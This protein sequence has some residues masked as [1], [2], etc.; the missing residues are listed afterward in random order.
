MASR[1]N[2]TT[3]CQ[4]LPVRSFSVMRNCGRVD[5]RASVRRSAPPLAS[6]GWL[7]TPG[8]AL[9]SPSR[10]ATEPDPY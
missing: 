7:A 4:R 1:V 10:K 5:V 2:V 6:S 9:A 3:T 8:M